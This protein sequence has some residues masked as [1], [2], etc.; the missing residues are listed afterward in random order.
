M[1]T[2]ILCLLLA[3][4]APAA[5]Q[6]QYDYS[7]NADGSIY[8]Y[9]NNPDGT[10]TLAG[11]SGPPWGV[12]IP[13]NINGL[14]VTSI[15]PNAFYRLLNL[16]SVVIPIGVTSIGVQAFEFCLSLTNVRDSR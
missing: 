7:T 14:T 16:T 10:I 1:K 8:S 5:L 3:L 4:A 13:T 11:Y 6:A 12:T 15:G 2:T 9:T